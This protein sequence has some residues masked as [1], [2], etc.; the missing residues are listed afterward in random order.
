M[1]EALMEKY[2]VEVD[3]SR[4]YRARGKGED[5]GSHSNS[6]EKLAKYAQLVRQTNLGSYVKMHLDRHKIPHSRGS[7]CALK[8]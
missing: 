6:Y 7:S 8:L 2:G 1:G 3:R 4:L 5:V